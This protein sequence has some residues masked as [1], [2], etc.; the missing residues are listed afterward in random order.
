MPK[1]R[2]KPVV[3][4]AVRLNQS[5]TVTTLEG[6]MTGDKGDWLI[7]GVEGEQYFCKDSIFQKTYEAEGIDDDRLFWDEDLAGSPAFEQAFGKGG[8]FDRVFGGFGPFGSAFRTM[9]TKTTR[10]GK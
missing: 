6:I 10:S 4:E 8:T 5:M 3:I 7:T 9:T 1:F 2:K